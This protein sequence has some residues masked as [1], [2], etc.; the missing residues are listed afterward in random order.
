MSDIRKWLKIMESVPAT[1]L[2][3]PPKDLIFKKD[4]TVMVSPHVGGGTGRFMHYT[5]KGAMVDIKGIARELA[6][7]EFSSPERDYEDA[8]QKGN[9]WF[10]MSKEPET[11]G[12][13][14]DKPEFRPGDMVKIADVYGTVIGP[15]F[16]VFVAYSTSGQECIV[17]FDNK[18]IVVPTS[19]VGSVL[20]QNA[21]DNFEQVDNDGCLSPMSL[22]S[23]NVKIEQ[24]ST[25][26]STQEP[27]M[28]Q[29]DEF[30]R[31]MEAVEEAL[32]SE[33]KTEI[34]E[35]M[36]PQMMCGCGAWDCPV[37]FPFQDEMPGMDG[38]MDGIGGVH[39][40]GE[41]CPMC[42]NHSDGHEHDDE[43]EVMPMD[44]P[45]EFEIEFEDSSAGGC[46]AGGL[47][48]AEDEPIDDYVSFGDRMDR[49]ASGEMD[50][51]DEEDNEFIEKPRSG[52]GIKI[53]D[54]IK[55][56]LEYRKAGGQNSPLTKAEYN[57]DE[58]NPY[59]GDDDD[60]YS[61]IGHYEPSERDMPDYDADP[62]AARERDAT[63]AE[64]GEFAGM[65]DEGMDAAMEMI[66][67]IKY[68]QSM[69]LSK[70]S[71]AY[72]E[73]QMAHMSPS[74]LK[75]CYAE[76]MG[77]VTED[78]TMP[79]TGAMPTG[80]MPTPPSSGG[81]ASAGA[82]YAPGT[83][84]TMPESTNYQGKKTMENV[85]KDVAAML[86]SL[87]K[88]DKLTESVAPVLMARPLEE[89]KD[90]KPEWLIN[91]EKKAE[92]KEGKDVEEDSHLAGGKKSKWSDDPKDH[93]KAGKEE[94]EEKWAGDTK[95]NPEKKGM[96]KGKSK[97]DLE[98]E[99]SHLKKSGPHEKGSA[100]YT[101]EKELNFAIRAK[102][103]WKEG[104]EEV[105]KEEAD[106]EV[107]E[108]M[109]RFASLGNMKGYGR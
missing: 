14:K 39:P 54:I 74:Q 95:L 58:A 99:L 80:S 36:P 87:K 103:G 101:K 72:S 105:V 62:M 32:T 64:M 48:M 66:S 5:P 88:Y 57:L 75:K 73:D 55:H 25:G 12:S 100:G 68:M 108:W 4:A 65:S 97:A 53:G 89:K 17:S 93:F 106:P 30:T 3:Q 19:N 63:R 79:D 85:D 45:G 94:V 41:V 43:M 104:V 24:L 1:F 22:G 86:Q 49:P 16:G 92:R 13:M 56:P 82:Q 38:A 27:A 107:M 15:G 26:M 69:G 76:V 47:A 34:E 40:Q 28:D 61:D 59:A 83:A 91:A 6:S 8:Y 81:G 31:W 46:A 33:G 96:F 78:D 84:P 10:H 42:G 60:D 29:R 98:S 90:G 44:G 109:K 102:S 18:E 71:T 50:Q 35:D 67:Q 20:E 77:D 52:K 11:V 23:E 9:D 51:M 7:D 70:A 37:C 2:N 21:K